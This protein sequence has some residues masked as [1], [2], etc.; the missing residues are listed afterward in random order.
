MFIR[1]SSARNDFGVGDKLVA[2]GVVATPRPSG[3]NS[4]ATRAGILDAAEKLFAGH[5]YSAAST[6]SITLSD[7][8]CKAGD[9]EAAYRYLLP[10]LAGRLR[11][12]NLMHRSGHYL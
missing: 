12:Q 6:R 11:S 8:K 5:G 10:F 1:T 2:K 3:V 9:T 7:G 4:E